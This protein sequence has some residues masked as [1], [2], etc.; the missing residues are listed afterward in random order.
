MAYIGQARGRNENIRTSMNT[1]TPGPQ[2]GHVASLHLHPLKAGDPLQSVEVIEVI[3]ARGILDEPR[4]FGRL[5]RKTGQ[6]S[7]RQVTLIE[8][9]QIG[10]HAGALGLSSIPPGAVRSN[11]ETLG[12]NLVALIGFEIEIGEAVLQ[13]QPRR[14]RKMPDVDV[15]SNP[16]FLVD[17]QQRLNCA[18]PSFFSGLWFLSIPKS[19]RHIH[20]G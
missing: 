11:I 7:K 18:L 8:R 4:Y 3:E 16:A 19:S 13:W 2:N 5:S 10:Q 15:E 20:I 6:L 12:I 17:V 14:K 9:E 1:E